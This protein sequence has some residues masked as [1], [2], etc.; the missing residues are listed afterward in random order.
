MYLLVHPGASGFTLWVDCT[1]LV[2]EPGRRHRFSPCVL[3][4]LAQPTCCLHPEPAF[5]SAGVAG[6]TSRRGSTARGTGSGCS[7]LSANSARTGNLQPTAMAGSEVGVSRRLCHGGTCKGRSPKRAGLTYWSTASRSIQAQHLAS[8][9]A[10]GTA[11]SRSLGE[12]QPSVPAAGFQ[13]G[14]GS[15]RRNCSTAQPKR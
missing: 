11:A 6:V 10:G 1:D 4:G 15:L 13:N 9:A 14:S 2:G 3:P 12:G 7:R 8:P 5:E